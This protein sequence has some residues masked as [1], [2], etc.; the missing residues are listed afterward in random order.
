[1]ALLVR[2]LAARELTPVAFKGAARVLRQLRGL[3]ESTAHTEVH[4][5]SPLA[6]CFLFDTG[7]DAHLTNVKSA[8]KPGSVRKCDVSVNGISVEQW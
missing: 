5:S 3:L 4:H 6:M 1:M 2:Q 7:A 8:F